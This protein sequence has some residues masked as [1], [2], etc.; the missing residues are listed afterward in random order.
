MSAKKKNKTVIA[1][2]IQEPQED[3][4]SMDFGEIEGDNLR[5]LHQAFITD[6]IITSSMFQEVDIRLYF[7]DDVERKKLVKIV[8][9]YITKQT[10]DIEPTFMKERFDKIKLKKERLGVRIEKIFDD[11]FAQEYDK[12]LVLG[13]RT[14]TVT[15][16]M[17][18]SALQLLKNS[19][20]V[21]GPTPEG[22]YYIIGMS[23]KQHI[24]LS[25]FDWKSPT[26]Y[27]DVV[28]CLKEKKLIWKEL[29]IWYSVDTV[30]ELE[31]TIRDINQLRLQ[32][33]EIT[34]HETEI[35]LER[36]F[37]KIENSELD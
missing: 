19:D 34:A 20:T 21:F 32:G 10:K 33:D 4:S 7:V 35:V 23:G 5:F 6:T 1:I 25:Q 24:Q 8:T 26:I 11:C 13:S 3:G 30:E 17:I 2:C 28:D 22:R 14:P 12:V 15:T 29:D 31:M 18:G 36:I 16:E 27:H 37:S 9:D